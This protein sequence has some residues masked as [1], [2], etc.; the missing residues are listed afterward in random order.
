MGPAVT[1]G[2]GGETELNRNTADP[3]MATVRRVMKCAGSRPPV[4]SGGP[5]AASLRILHR[6]LAGLNSLGGDYAAVEPSPYL[7]GL[8]KAAGLDAGEANPTR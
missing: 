5:L 4:N 3:A 2:A 7:E 6:R 1:G 8:W